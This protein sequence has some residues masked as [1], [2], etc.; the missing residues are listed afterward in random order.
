M[1]RT[2]RACRDEGVLFA[3]VHDSFWTHACHVDQMHAII[4]RE[5]IGLH[6][7]VGREGGRRARGV[8][9]RLAC[10]WQPAMAGACV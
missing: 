5:F 7:E 2:A 9:L 10:C 4:R 1:M 6:S 3:G 8:L